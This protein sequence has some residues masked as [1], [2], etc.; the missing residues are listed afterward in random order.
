MFRTSCLKW[1]KY[2]K[3]PTCLVDI[4]LHSLLASNA[5]RCILGCEYDRSDS[6]VRYTF[7]THAL[8]TVSDKYSKLSAFVT[9]VALP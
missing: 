8:G 7:M 9:E 2:D 3:G 1:G 5:E 6:L 4:F